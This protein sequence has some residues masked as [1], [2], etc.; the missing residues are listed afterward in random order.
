MARQPKKRGKG[1]RRAKQKPAVRVPW[2]YIGLA[3]VG[4]VA[5]AGLMWWL[6]N[7]SRPAFDG[8]RAYAALVKQVDFGPRVP[9]TA[10]HDQTR[11]YLIETLSRYAERVGPQPVTWT[12]PEDTTLTLQGTNIIASFNL[13]PRINKRIMLGAHWD[14]RPF[15]DHDPD[16][17]KRDLPVP[18]A[19][20]GASGVAVLLELA[21][22]LHETPPDV[23]VD[24]ILFDLEDMGSRANVDSTTVQVPYCLGSELF[25]INNPTYRPTFGIILDMVG[26]QNPRFP[27]EINSLRGARRIVEKVWAAADEVGAEAFLDVDGQSVVDDHI[28]FLRKGI[29]VIDVIQNPFPDYWH[30]TADTPEKCSPATLQQ[31]GEVMIEVIYGE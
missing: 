28:A 29:P 23:G 9:G 6:S 7:P 14:T 24:L 8:E 19:N 22:V 27:R 20:D 3:A 4:V 17:T 26:G 2:L 11:D 21:R 30:T 12:S 10:A 16:S 25:V 13:Q 18:G 5:L 15:A 31:V 1:K